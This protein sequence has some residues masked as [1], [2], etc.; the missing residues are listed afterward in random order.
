[1]KRARATERDGDAANRD[2]RAEGQ[3][4]GYVCVCREAV[5]Y[6]F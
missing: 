2:W 4:V 5:G 6:T 1:M 3:A